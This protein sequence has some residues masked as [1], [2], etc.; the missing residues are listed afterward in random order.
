MN[1]KRE[2]IIFAGF[3]TVVFLML[4]MLCLFSP[5]NLDSTYQASIDSS[6]EEISLINA[7]HDRET[8]SK[9]LLSEAYEELICEIEAE[10]LESLEVLKEERDERVRE[11]S[12]TLSIDDPLTAQ[13]IQEVFD[14]EYI[15]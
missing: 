5:S 13:K 9:I 2:L 11:L 6:R 1:Y 15:K 8:K 4:F 12:T 14:F 10:H 7:S 3:M